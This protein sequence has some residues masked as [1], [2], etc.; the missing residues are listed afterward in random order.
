MTHVW[1]FLR[2]RQ[3]WPAFG[4]MFFSTVFPIFKRVPPKDLDVLSV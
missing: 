1:R 2:V 4:K 3:T